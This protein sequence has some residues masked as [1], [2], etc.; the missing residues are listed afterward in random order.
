MKENN[1]D[2]LAM[3]Y[4][5]EEMSKNGYSDEQ[6]QGFRVYVYGPTADP[7]NYTPDGR[8]IGPAVGM[9]PPIFGGRGSRSRGGAP[10]KKIAPGRKRD[11]KTGRFVDEPKLRGAVGRFSRKN[12]YPHDYRAGVAKDVIRRNTDAQGQII[13]PATGKV[14]PPDQVTIEHKTPVVEHWNTQG[15][16]QTQQQRIDWYND[17]NNLTVKPKSPN[18]AEGAARQAQPGGLFIQQTGAGYSPD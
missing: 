2:A 14:I 7:I 10:C 12:Q 6:I 5:T 8:Y 16:F 1:P 4:V 17:L 11:S 9:P 18:S 15:R 13:D 3:N